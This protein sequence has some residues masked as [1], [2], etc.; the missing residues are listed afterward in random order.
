MNFEGKKLLVIASHPDDEILGCGGLIGRVKNE[1]GEVYVLVMTVGN[2]ELYGGHS[3][4]KTR[5]KETEDVMKFIKVDDYDIA[6]PGD[7]YHLKLDTLPQKTMIDIIEKG[8]KVSLNKVKPD[9]LAFPF[10]GSSNQDHR[11]VS[12]ASFT[13][14]RS[15]PHQLKSFQSLIL[16]Y[17]DPVQNNLMNEFTPNFYVNIKDFIDFKCK[18]LSLYK[19]QVRGPL[20]QC[21]PETIT[22][23][24]QSR[25]REV[26]IEAAEAFMLYRLLM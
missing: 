12:Q 25:G 13:A 10:N 20:H 6:L 18:A 26:A 2:T 5:I 24:A 9:I 4:I 8:S 14:C 17:E 21:S 11:A 19:S 15:R 23:K 3:D 22:I 16:L 1:G 7:E